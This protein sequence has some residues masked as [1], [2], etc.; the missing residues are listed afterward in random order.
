MKRETM[1]SRIL[2]KG[3]AEVGD[4]ERE[5]AVDADD[6]RNQHWWSPRKGLAGGGR[7]GWLVRDLCWC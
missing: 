3:N 2:K 4:E 6:D 1:E 5:D 7:L